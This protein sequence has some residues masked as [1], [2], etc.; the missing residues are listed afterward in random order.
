VVLLTAAEA[1]KA[2]AVLEEFRD[3]GIAADLLDRAEIAARWP[4]IGTDGIVAGFWEPAGGYA[5]P[6]ATAG[7]LL[8]EARRDGAVVVDGRAD[9]VLLDG[10]RVRGVAVDGHGELAAPAV[11]LAAGC[12]TP[13]LL[14]PAVRP[15]LRTRR[16]RYA[17]VGWPHRPVPAVMDNV[18]GLWAR[19]HGEDALLVGR[20]IEEWDVEPRLGTDI[21][22]DQ[23]T[24]IRDGALSRWPGITTAPL[25][26]ARWGTDLYTPSGPLLG[27]VEAYPGLVLAAAWS[28]GGFKTAPAAGEEVGH[29]V[30]AILHR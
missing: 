26:G 27:P 10:D 21:A 5:D 20:P 6:P 19:A 9:A 24:F 12:G 25:V 8:D 22:P 17:L 2:D 15:S 16:I 1:D 3:R 23:L 4:S 29:S 7:L 28:G 18:T 11:V 13:R 14:P 30:A